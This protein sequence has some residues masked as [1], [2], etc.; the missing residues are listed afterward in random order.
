ML[1]NLLWKMKGVQHHNEKAP[2]Q[3][4]IG[5]LKVEEKHSR[6]MVGRSCPTYGLLAC[7]EVLKNIPAFNESNLCITY[8]IR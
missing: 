3:S 1:Q 8:K 6:I 5:F 4:I 2:F 7:N